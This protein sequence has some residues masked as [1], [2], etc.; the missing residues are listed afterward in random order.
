MPKQFEVDS[1]LINH[2]DAI[3]ADGM[4][5]QKTP[6]GWWGIPKGTLTPVHYGSLRGA[7]IAATG[8]DVLLPDNAN[9]NRVFSA[10]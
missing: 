8:I 5:L 6:T 1:I 3:G 10:P 2:I 9:V 7:L 4:G